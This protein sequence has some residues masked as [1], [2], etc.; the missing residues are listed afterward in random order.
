MSA[1]YRAILLGC[2]SVFAV[3][4]VGTARAQVA[5]KSGETQ[6]PPAAPASL[7]EI[8]VTSQRRE[9]RLQDVPI[10]VTAF[11]SADLEANRIQNVTDLSSLA[12]NVLISSGLPGLQ[13][14][15]ATIR[16]LVAFPLTSNAQKG[17]SVYLDG[18]YL[19][20]NDGAIFDVADIAR[21]EILKG[22]QG[23]LFGR[24]SNGGAISLTTSNPSGE[25]HVKQ[26]LTFGN[27][28]EFRSKTKIDLPSWE[29][30]SASFTYTHD[31]RD[32]DIRNLGAGT[33]WNF[34]LADTGAQ[35][36]RTSPSRLGDQDINS[37]GLAVRLQATDQLDV[38]YKFDYTHNDFTTAGLAPVTGLALLAPQPFGVGANPASFSSTRPDAVNNAFTTPSTEV[39]Y[40]HNLT[41]TYSLNENIRLQDIF[42]ARFSS[43]VGMTELS[44]AGGISGAGFGFPTA[45][46]IP[47]GADT[48][49]DATQA[50]NEIQVTVATKPVTLTSGYIYFRDRSS[51]GGIEDLGALSTNPL[52]TTL[53]FPVNGAFLIPPA[54]NV[55]QFIHTSSHSNA[56]YAQGEFHV[57]PTLDLVTGVRN[58]WDHSFSD[59]NVGGPFDTNSSKPTYLLGV[60]YRPMEDVL[61]YAKWSTGFISG[62]VFD[63]AAFLP[64]T[65]N[66]YEAG[67]K[68]DWLSHRLRT[69][70]ALFN[71]TYNNLQQVAQESGKNVIINSGKARARGFEFEGSLIPVEGVSL[72]ANLGYTNFRILQLPVSQTPPPGEQYYPVKRPTVT[73]NLAAQ[74]ESPDKIWN[75]RIL[76]RLDGQFASA[77]HY[78]PFASGL[79]PQDTIALTT[80]KAHWIANA[81]LALTDLPIAG[82]RGQIALWGRNIFNDKSIVGA[83]DF[84]DRGLIA[85]NFQAAAT[86]GI[87]LSV[88]F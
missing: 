76:M 31:Q 65:A 83:A 48:V 36:L 61:T 15:S 39:N 40:G 9:E 34:S 59:D 1:K 51:T 30:L 86:Y 43:L 27:Y 73:S 42:G 14:I 79:N 87:D 18:V 46:V 38:I 81:R 70:I 50:S 47:F 54:A 37:V 58:T 17:V 88:E 7:E 49:Y 62:G 75:G 80:V 66:S 71:V 28:H 33:V 55:G 3:G 32:G 53:I 20:T 21:I 5:Q 4:F 78:T 72:N 67:L 74:Y 63:G 16:G 24:N 26:T 12:P 57:A 19:G 6:S 84:T 60:N 52:A 85:A 44:G 45:V 23:T 56:V 82:A 29:R 35:A 64:E 13:A 41:A 22:P 77:V 69:N 10:S 8:V 25:F 2:C 11:T 68:A